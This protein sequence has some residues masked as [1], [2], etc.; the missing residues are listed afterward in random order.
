LAEVLE[1]ASYQLQD[2]YLVSRFL[3]LNQTAIVKLSLHFN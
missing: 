3:H 2:G 1:L